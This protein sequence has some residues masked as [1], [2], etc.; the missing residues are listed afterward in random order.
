MRTVLDASA[1]IAAAAGTRGSEAI[2]ERLS[3]ATSV[4]APDLYTAEVANALWKYVV[5]GELE[6]AQA[7][8]LL[9]TALALIDRF[10]ASDSIIHEA[11]RE[12]A[13]SGHPVYDL[14]YAVTARR[15]GATVL[16]SDRRLQKLLT[17]M[18]IPS[19]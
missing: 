11:L 7:T 6:I 19:A 10:V 16:T 3:A 14:L 5:A 8:E 4:L 13:A 12:A 2:L 9:E 18:Q 15:E 17:R 1:A